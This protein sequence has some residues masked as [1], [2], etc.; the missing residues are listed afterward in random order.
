MKKLVTAILS[1][2]ILISLFPTSALATEALPGNSNM[3]VYLHYDDVA[4]YIKTAIKSEC[5]TEF[6][7]EQVTYYYGDGF[8]V[9]D[10]PNIGGY[11]L[12]QYNNERTSITVNGVEVLESYSIPATRGAT[13]PPAPSGWSYWGTAPITLSIGGLAVSV[14]AG[15]VTG[16]LA[17]GLAGAVVSFLMSAFG[18][19]ILPNTA[20][21]TVYDHKYVGNIDYTSGI[22]DMLHITQ[23][24]YGTTQQPETEFI[25]EGQ[26]I[27]THYT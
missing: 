10:D 3:L 16:A 19:T 2:A 8:I 23:V 1:L 20:C 17:G 6:G 5:F 24:Y 14:A 25:T 9:V 4:D 21:V 13:A 11:Y 7:V 12:I 18:E 26:S 22:Y 15:V 27:Q